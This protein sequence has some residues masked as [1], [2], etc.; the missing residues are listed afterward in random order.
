MDRLK[1]LA[2]SYALLLAVSC[3][4]EQEQ[5]SPPGKESPPAKTETAPALTQGRGTIAGKVIFK[6]SYKASKLAVGKDKDVCG[7]GKQD[8][9]LLVGGAGELKNAV[10]QIAGLRQGKTAGKEAVIDQVKCQYVPHVLVVSAGSTVTIKNS[11]GILHNVHSLSQVNPPF[12]RAQ[13]KFM[14]ELKE[15]FAKPEVIRL[16]CDVHGWMS[17]WVIVTENAYFDVTQSDGAFKLA[18]VPAGKYS[19]E[20]WHETL[21]SATQPVE[22]KAGETKNVTIEFQMNK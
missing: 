16:R 10:V 21:G 20:V 7:D 11:D 19:L 6:G 5:K 1:C 2:A 18:E 13:P 22:L 4:K 8:P 3:S 12:N 14:K 17:G 9:S 15:P